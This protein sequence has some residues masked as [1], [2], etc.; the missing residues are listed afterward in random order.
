[1]MNDDELVFPVLPLRMD[2]PFIIR[3][4]SPI[5]L[6]MA[7]VVPFSTYVHGYGVGNTMSQ[8]VV[9]RAKFHQKPL[10]CQP[11]VQHNLS[12]RGL[13]PFSPTLH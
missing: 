12:W 2:H 9:S 4:S 11:V 1:M 3:L 6:V 7:R 13:C 10:R 8:R 5:Q